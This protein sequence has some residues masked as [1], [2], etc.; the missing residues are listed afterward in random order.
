MATSDHT[1]VLPGGAALAG[2]AGDIEGGGEVAA[3]GYWEN[4]FRRLRRDRIA[5]AGAIVIIVFLIVPFIGLPIAER[6]AGHSPNDLVSGGVQNFVPV[7]PF[8]TVSDGHGGTTYL[9]LG[10]SDL[11]GRD[12]FLRLLAGAQVSIEVGILA[13]LV[14]LSLGLLLGLL[15]GFYGGATDTIVSRLTEIVMAF[16]LLLFLIAL[17][18]TLGDRLDKI[19]LWGLLNPG[20]FTLTMVIGLFTWFYPARIVRAQV[21]SLREKEFIEA[22]R[23]VGSS[24]FRIMRSHLL[25]HL[26]GTMIV[27][28]TLTVAINIL[29]EST[30][31]FLGVGLPPPNASWGNM[32][33]EATQLYTIQ[34]WLIAWPGLALLILTLAFNLLGDGLRDA[35]DPRATL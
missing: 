17:G 11:V 29:L 21:L 20:V 16:P 4:A 10:A 8:S 33:D 3:R 1:T 7:G 5:I 12:E 34:P 13:T 19:T 32:L 35:L 24:N 31:S 18:A 28:G 23:M 15:A 30:L 22:A 9:L 27:Y 6:W 25:P 14:G 26:V 2:S